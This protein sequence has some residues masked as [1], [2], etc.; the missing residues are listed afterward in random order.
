M[1]CNKKSIIYKRSSGCDEDDSGWYIGPINEE[2]S[3]ELNL[4]TP[5]NY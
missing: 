1:C 2:V 3:E 5:M 4:Y